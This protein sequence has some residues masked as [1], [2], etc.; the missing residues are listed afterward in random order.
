MFILAII[1][2]K[3]ERYYINRCIDY[4]IAQNIKVA[5]IDNGST[6]GSFEIADSYPREKVVHLERYPYPGYYDWEGIL[7]RKE[8]I[9]KELEPD[10]VIHHDCDEIMESS[11]CW[12][13]LSRGIHRVARMGFD[14]INFDE[15]VFLP[16]DTENHIGRNYRKTMNRYY[17][18][19]PS[20]HRLVR[21]FR[22]DLRFSNVKSG[23]HKLTGSNVKIY[24]TNFTLRHYICLSL[25]HARTK[26]LE[27][28]YSDKEVKN[29]KWHGN[30]T[31]I[32]KQ[33]LNL[34]RSENLQRESKWLPC[35]PLSRK[36]PKQT[37]FWEW[38]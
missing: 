27:R 4:L 16:A 24:G 8:Q 6:D 31:I 34:P 25:E 21:A 3:D 37:H 15:F 30:R 13:T 1:A 14:A 19:E 29:L 28:K 36:L 10:W 5:V 2:M 22:N 11:R 18:F 26:Y 12:E 38:N 9:R 33:N 23:G 20:P 32:T 35:F 17:F 7:R